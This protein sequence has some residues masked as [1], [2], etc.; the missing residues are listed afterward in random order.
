MFKLIVRLV[1]FA[2]LA[3]FAY[4]Y[5]NVRADAICAHNNVVHAQTSK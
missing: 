1:L 4:D 5:Y 2:A 3:F